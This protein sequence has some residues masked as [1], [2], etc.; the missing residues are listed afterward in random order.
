MSTG[1]YSP[2]LSPAKKERASFSDD[3]PPSYRSNRS[4]NSPKHSFAPLEGPTSNETRNSNSSKYSDIMEYLENESF[5][6]TISPQKN[7][8]TI[9]NV[10]NVVGKLALFKFPLL[11]N[12]FNLILKRIQAEFCGQ[13]FYPTQHRVK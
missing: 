7:V 11:I 6:S 9:N 10:H 3:A 12:T 5:K 8:G 1:R 2:I 13:Y 4:E